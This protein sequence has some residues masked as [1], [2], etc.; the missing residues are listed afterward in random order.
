MGLI[1]WRVTSPINVPDAYP[2]SPFVTSHSVAPSDAIVVS[3]L[4]VGNSPGD[5]ES[6]SMTRTAKFI[7]HTTV[8]SSQDL[9]KGS[10]Q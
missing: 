3:G 4:T 2:P 10:P 9:T 5:R 1:S 6:Q 8:Y 7:T